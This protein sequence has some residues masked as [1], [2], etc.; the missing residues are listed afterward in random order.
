[1][2]VDFLARK[3]AKKAGKQDRKQ[4]ERRVRKKKGPRRL[5]RGVCFQDPLLKPEDLEE[6]DEPAAWLSK[7]EQA[8]AAPQE[9]TME[10]RIARELIKKQAETGKQAEGKPNKKEKQDGSRKQPAAE[11]APPKRRKL[12]TSSR[13]GQEAAERPLPG[14]EHGGGAAPTAQGAAPL[15]A[16]FPDLIQRVMVS[17]GFQEP[18]PV[19]EQAWPAL[20]RGDNVRAVAEPGAGKT[21]AFLLPCAVRLA[22]QAPRRGQPLALVLEPTRELAQQV[23]AVWKDLTRLTGLEC[24]V[25]HGGVPKQEH[26]SAD[27]VF[28]GSA[29]LALGSQ[30][31]FLGSKHMNIIVCAIFSNGG[32][33]KFRVVSLPALPGRGT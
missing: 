33:H 24:G 5:C 1:M 9:T 17:K 31:A 12:S 29:G 32:I 4:V 13:L 21:L 18:T 20:L 3:A 30:S 27:S 2:G 8:E 23:A 26:V 25:I 22:A 15:L 7:N 19:Q 14:P 11:E 28:I 16:A 10:S 6:G